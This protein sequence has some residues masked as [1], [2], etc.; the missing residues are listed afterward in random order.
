MDA[1]SAAETGHDGL[2]GWMRK[3]ETA[4]TT[5][6][7]DNPLTLAQQFDFYGK[8]ETQH[9]PRPLRVVYAKAGNK[10]AACLI[11]DPAAIIDHKLYWGEPDS[12]DEAYFLIAILNSEEAR[13]RIEGL[14]SRGLFGARDFDKVMFTLPIPRFS[15]DIANHRDLAQAGRDAE[16]EA[17]VVAMTDGTPFTRAR[18]IVRETLQASGTAGRIDAL[19]ASLLDGQSPDV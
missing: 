3:A 4:W 17:G 10:P 15:T 14:Q 11:R 16:A 6:K 8:L 13:S 5:S 9:P 18:R 2:A 19:V 12:E 7:G 1:A